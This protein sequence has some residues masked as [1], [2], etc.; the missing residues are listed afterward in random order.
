MRSFYV[1]MAFVLVTTGLIYMG[2]CIQN[3]RVQKCLNLAEK[4]VK[5]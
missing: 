3:L 2:L 1:L 5:P 4:A